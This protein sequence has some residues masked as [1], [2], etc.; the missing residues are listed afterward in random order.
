MKI[1]L[2]CHTRKIKDGDPIQREISA[3]AFNQKIINNDV[4]IVAITNHN[5]FDLKQYK[6]ILDFAQDNYIVWPGIEID[7]IDEGSKGHVIV[8][9]NPKEIEKFQSIINNLIY[10]KNLN[11]FSINITELYNKFKGLDVFYAFHYNKNPQLD[12]EIIKKFENMMEEKHRVFYE[13]TN[14]RKMGILTNKG[15]KSI[16]GSDVRDW[17]KYN[18]CELPILKLEVDSFEQFLLLAKKDYSVVETLL[19][20]KN[21]VSVDCKVSGRKPLIIPVYDDVNIIF[22]AKGSGKS[23]NLEIFNKYF[24][25]QGKMIAY[26]EA[27]K[28]KEKFENKL[29]ISKEERKLGKF[30]IE[31][32]EEE[33]LEI[34]KWEEIIPT[35]IKD[36]IDHYE[37]KDAS[38]IR[39]KLGILEITNFENL[40]SEIKKV[41]EALAKMKDF[42]NELTT[43][44]RKFL[45][46]DVYEEICSSME[47]AIEELHVKRRD[48]FI[49]VTSN[50]LL[51]KSLVVIRNLVDANTETKSK[52]VSC[53]F[54]KFAENR[55]KLIKNINKIEK[56]LK[57][58]PQRYQEKLGVLDNNKNIY[59]ETVYEVLNDKSKTDEF[60]DGI[61][62][63]KNFYKAFYEVKN[64]MFSEN[65]NEKIK[66][67]NEEE[68]YNVISLKQLVGIIKRTVLKNNDKF[69]IYNPSKGEETMIILQEVLESENE[70]YILDEPEKSLG[71]TYVNDVIVPII[72]TLAKRRKTIIIATHNANIAV[73]TLPYTSIYKE[74]DG[75]YHTYVGNPFTNMIINIENDTDKKDWK[76]TSLKC[77]E[78]GSIAFDERGEI[79]GRK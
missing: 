22:G 34:R 4:K 63:L 1:D 23:K 64:A 57:R 45:S 26:Y 39:S 44:I 10:E 69:K 71:N 40:K 27:D 78:G 61:R 74:Y 3:E 20:R 29:R 70:I 54:K 16:L 28:T 67:L 51:N 7:I 37:T 77:L 17:D 58:S 18:E 76:E 36:Y 73:R 60:E 41:N 13:A 46:Y 31:S 12:I 14:Y 19:S 65:V 47:K 32:C 75:K 5:Y 53:N 11:E 62:K 6:E 72:N 55:I 56:N 2:H 24:T 79:Y 15:F 49:D 48:I 33:I 30:Q 35:P 42:K 50:K 68:I 52:P 9:S 43:N 66:L 38:K 21:K 8:I 59:I 25:S